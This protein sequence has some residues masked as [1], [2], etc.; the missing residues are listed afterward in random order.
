MS[1]PIAA[2][3]RYGAAPAPDLAPRASGFWSQACRRLLHNRL[4]AVSLVVLG[5]IVVAALFAPLIAPHDP[6]TQDLTATFEKP[7][8]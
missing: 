2:P 1:R 4:A 3:I 7:S 6:S 8:L 5:L